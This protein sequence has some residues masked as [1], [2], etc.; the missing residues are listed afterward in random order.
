V[1]KTGNNRECTTVHFS[2]D[3]QFQSF[4]KKC[5]RTG[6]MAQYVGE[7][8]MQARRPE[9]IFPALGFQNQTK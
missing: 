8:A 6:E 1:N 9:F 4:I 3:I 5:M 2:C 7:L